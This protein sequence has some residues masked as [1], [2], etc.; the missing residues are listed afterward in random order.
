MTEMIQRIVA[1]A[2]GTP[3]RLVLLNDGAVHDPTAA[4]VKEMT[5]RGKTNVIT[6]S[7]D[8]INVGETVD[9][10]TCLEYVIVAGDIPQPDGDSEVYRAIGYIEDV[11]GKWEAGPGKFR[12]YTSER[13]ADA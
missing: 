4:S 7:G 12:V 1:P 8:Q 9:G 13:A 10:R 11:A 2:I 6:R 5:I 3:I